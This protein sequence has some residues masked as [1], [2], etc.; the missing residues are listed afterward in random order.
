MNRVSHTHVIGGGGGGGGGGLSTYCLIGT[1]KK[2]SK[3]IVLCS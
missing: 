1:C 2:G 3:L